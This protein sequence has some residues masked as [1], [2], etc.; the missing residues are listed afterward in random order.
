[1]SLQ[2][3]FNGLILVVLMELKSVLGLLLC[4]AKTLDNFKLALILFSHY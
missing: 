2:E 3:I 1:M 4:E